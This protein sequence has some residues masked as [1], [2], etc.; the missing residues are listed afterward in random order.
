MSFTRDDKENRKF[1]ADPSDSSKVVVKTKVENQNSDPIPVTIVNPDS[2]ID[3]EVTVSPS[4]TIN[5]STPID[6]SVTG[7]VDL[8]DATAVRVDVT[9]AAVAT[10]ATIQNAS[11]NTNATIQNSSLNTNATIQN[12]ELDV[13]VTNPFQY[14][15]AMVYDGSQ[16]RFQA[17]DTNGKAINLDHTYYTSTEITALGS[18]TDMNLW[19]SAHNDGML[20]YKYV[21]SYDDEFE[22]EV[23]LTHPS[24]GDSNKCLKLAYAY[25]TENSQKVVKS[26]VAT[27]TD[28]TFDATILG[29]ITV[30]LGTITSPDPNS[31]IAVG[32]D[33]CTVA[34]ANSGSGSLTLSISGTNADKYTLRNVTDG[35]TGSSLA[36]DAAKSYVLETAN[37]FSGATYSHSLTVTATNS[38]YGNTGTANVATAGTFTGGPTWANDYYIAGS[39]SGCRQECHISF[40]TANSFS[41]TWWVY[42]ANYSNLGYSNSFYP[43]TFLSGSTPGDTTSYSGN[44]PGGW[45][46]F[47]RNNASSGNPNYFTFSKTNTLLGYYDQTDLPLSGSWHHCCVTWDSTYHSSSISQS[48][49]QNGMTVYV[50]NVAHGKFAYSDGGSSIAA[51]DLVFTG[52]TFG[53]HAANY[54]TNAYDGGRLTDVAIWNNH[55][56]TSTERGLLY[57]SGTPLDAE[58]TTGLTTPNGYWLFED[59]SD[60]TL[61]TVSGASKGTTTGFTRTAY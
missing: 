4:V 55:L 56:L 51:S 36:Y 6:V 2:N 8:D 53:S 12:S 43:I 29:T 22:E 60:L 46:W 47:E 19:L 34:A 20:T 40:S 33:I 18:S 5:D 44:Y 49:A 7:Q 41:L 57:N 39:G 9:N 15:Y 61:D 35:T 23:F 42:S 30:T 52:V 26:I 17:S 11:L 21:G 50:D 3:L 37:D 28:W 13:N 14:I 38:L 10:N 27:V 1:E 25:S 59:S 58:N 24:L 31:S 54:K 45:I 32:T 16:W 48:D